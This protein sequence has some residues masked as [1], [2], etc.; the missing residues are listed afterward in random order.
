MKFYSNYSKELIDNRGRIKCPSNFYDLFHNYFYFCLL[1]K[2]YKYKFLSQLNQETFTVFSEILKVPFEFC[3]SIG[4]SD[5][6]VGYFETNCRKDFNNDIEYTKN[7]LKK[8]NEE[9]KKLILFY[10]DDYEEEF[11]FL[12][13]NLIKNNSNVIIFRSSWTKTEDFKNMFGC[14]TLND[15]FFSGKFLK[16][17]FSVGFCGCIK[18]Y[19]QSDFR[20]KIL[21]PLSNKSQYNFIFRKTWGDIGTNSYKSEFKVS[22]KKSRNEYIKNI[23]D[24]L[25]TICIRGGGNFSFR[26]AETLMMGRIPVLIDTDCLLPFSEDIPY[27]TNT[28]YITRE[29][30]NNFSCIHNLI[31]NYHNSHS[32]SELINIQKENRKLW[33]KY[34]T[35][36]GAFY[37]TLNIIQRI[38]EKM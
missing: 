16:K 5:Y 11:N 13:N 22:P 3:E 36:S 6:L 19:S 8:S 27:R 4:E 34:F 9:G 14:P 38:N 7:I 26:L 31:E 12:N 37:Q 21:P 15:D 20:E 23:E 29:N 17:Q 24:N 25:Y 1:P 28:V 32:E 30:S 10:G 35:V 33:E 2:N 18:D